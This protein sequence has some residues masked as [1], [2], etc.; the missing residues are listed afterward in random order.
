MPTPNFK[1]GLQNNVVHV[2]YPVAIGPAGSTRSVTPSN[3]F[4]FAEPPGAP[5]NPRAQ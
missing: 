4:V 2:F 1:T 5:T 3:P